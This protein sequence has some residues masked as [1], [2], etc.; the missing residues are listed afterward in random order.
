MNDQQL[1]EQQDEG[2]WISISDMMAGLMVI[3]LFVALS[4]MLDAQ[5]KKN[6]I[7]VER[8]SIKEIAV[9]YQRLQNDLYN[10]LLDEFK[11]N[12]DEWD[13]TID[14]PTLSVRFRAPDVLFEIGKADLQERFEG[15]LDDF[16][17]RYIRI[18]ALDDQEK[19]RDD[20]EEI[21][22]EGH[23]SSEWNVSVSQDKAYILNMKLSQDRTRAVLKHVLNIQK[24][25]M[26]KERDWVKKHLT[27]NGLSSSKLRFKNGD[28]EDKIQSRRVE[29]RVRTNAEEQIV[30]IIQEG[31]IVE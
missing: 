27:A 24:S 5:E 11:D 16:F 21:R 26:P 15:I 19:Y 12:L 23:T 7:E 13:A 22:I 9:T 25:P 20:I 1:P 28:E 14:K 29:F 17:P 8:D 31:G 2:Q 6:K 4:F 10:D 18:L 30:R 3:F